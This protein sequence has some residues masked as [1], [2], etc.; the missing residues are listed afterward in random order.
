MDPS[1]RFS[2]RLGTRHLP[3][4]IPRR[5]PVS[6]HSFF[7]VPSLTSGEGRRYLSDPIE[8]VRVATE[9]LLAEFLQE[10]RD[11]AIA[12]KRR[13]DKS[14]AQRERSKTDAQSVTGEREAL[15]DITLD[16][17]EN[18]EEDGE[19]EDGEEGSDMGG[20][21]AHYRDTGGT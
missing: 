14:R 8:D 12:Q 20:E 19:M 1:P 10:V 13:E 11:I 2:P 3:P 7:F 21:D 5:T 15:P 9:N 6:P 4:R 16:F 18:D 17:P